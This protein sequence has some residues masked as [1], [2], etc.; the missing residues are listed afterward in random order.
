[1][2]CAREGAYGSLEGAVR[3][4]Q[5]LVDRGFK[6]VAA[7]A[8]SAAVLSKQGVSAAMA[9]SDTI[10]KR[11]VELVI[12]I[13][14]NHSDF[15]PTRRLSV[16]YNIPLIT[17]HEQVMLFSRALASGEQLQVKSYDDHIPIEGLY[18]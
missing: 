15:Y 8:E 16:D 2:V 4:A 3:G 18:A 1:M 5:T 9:R 7:D 6:L 10:N 17:N 13:S 14:D 12:D 11:D